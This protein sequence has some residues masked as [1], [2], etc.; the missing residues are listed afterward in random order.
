MED[1]K[2]ERWEWLSKLQSVDLEGMP[3]K[4]FK[5]LVFES[6]KFLN[7]PSTKILQGYYMVEA[8]PSLTSEVHKTIVEFLRITSMTSKHLFKILYDLKMELS[9]GVNILLGWNSDSTALFTDQSKSPRIRSY[10][11]KEITLTVKRVNYLVDGG[12]DS[13]VINT[14]VMSSEF[15]PLLVDLEN[16][17]LNMFL[18]C[19]ECGEIYFHWRKR[20]RKYC[21]KA[22]QNRAGVKRHREK[23][24]TSQEGVS[25]DI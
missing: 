23:T 19:E 7:M 6:M 25:K 21:S 9:S 15:L 13:E 2:F 14:I 24:T 12:Y 18:K 1:R 16:I 20:Q 17:N 5:D 11:D 22:C 10:V 3:Q 4:D 8:D